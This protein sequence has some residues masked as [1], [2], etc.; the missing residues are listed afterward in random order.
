MKDLCACFR[1]V[2]SAFSAAAG[3]VSGFIVAGKGTQALLET[4]EMWPDFAAVAWVAG[5]YGAYFGGRK[6]AKWTNAAMK[7]AEHA[8]PTRTP[9]FRHNI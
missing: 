8:T 9:H 2:A 4:T 3:A 1:L 6:I 7:R 5:G